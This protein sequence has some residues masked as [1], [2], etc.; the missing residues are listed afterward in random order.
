MMD[1]DDGLRRHRQGGLDA[2]LGRGDRDGRAAAA[3]SSPCFACPTSTYAREL[4]PVHALPRRHRLAVSHGQPHRARRGPHGRPR[5][6]WI[7]WPTAF[8]GRTICALGDAAAMPVQRHPE[9]LLAMIRLSR[10]PHLQHLRPDAT[11]TTDITRLNAW[12]RLD[13]R[14]QAGHRGRRQHGDACR[15]CKL[16]V[17]MS[18]TSAITRN[19]RLRPTA[20]CAL[21]TSKRCPSRMPACATPVTN[22]MIVRTRSDKAI[23]AQKVGDGVPAHQPPARLPDLRPGRRVPAPGSGGGLRRLG[24]PLPTSPSA[25][26]AAQGRSARWCLDGNEPLHSLHPLRAL[27]PGDRRRDGTRHGRARRAL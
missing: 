5:C 21:S 17:Y 13:P 23:K 10:A 2:G 27:R 18:R 8:K 1:I 14:R 3:R 12:L 22:G 24:V 25:C 16:G 7:P 20:A 6:C 26:R 4:W 19:C 11:V 15:R 9:A